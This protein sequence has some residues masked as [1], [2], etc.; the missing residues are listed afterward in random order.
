MLLQRLS[1]RLR[2]ASSRLRRFL[3]LQDDVE[4][5]DDAGDVTK[6]GEENVDQEI[7]AA[8]TLEENTKRWEDDG[9]DDLE[10]VACGES[11]CKGCAV[12]LRLLRVEGLVGGR[13]G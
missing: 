5:M 6:N 1:S 8:A 2:T 13:I 12:K 4:G 9:E 7:A 10:N 3:I 11:H